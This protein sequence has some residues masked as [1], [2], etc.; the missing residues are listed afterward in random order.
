[1]IICYSDRCEYCDKYIDD[2]ENNYKNNEKNI[3]IIKLNVDN[4]IEKIWAKHM[5]ISKLP[6]TLFMDDNNKIRG[7][8]DGR[9]P[10]DKMNETIDKIFG[11]DIKNK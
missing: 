5:K 6:C 9:I 10:L 4:L 3:E 1:M 8:V 7:K 11:K 2:I